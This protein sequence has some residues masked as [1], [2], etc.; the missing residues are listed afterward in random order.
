M[1][2]PNKINVIIKCKC[3]W[4]IDILQIFMS[5]FILEQNLQH[6][7]CLWGPDKDGCFLTQISSAVLVTLEAIVRQQVVFTATQ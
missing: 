2:S 6:D 3:E 4:N 7:I 1:L 5:H